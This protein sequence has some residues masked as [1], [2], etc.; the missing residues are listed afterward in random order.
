[1]DINTLL[2]ELINVIKWE[3]FTNI[4]ALTS[5]ILPIILSA[6]GLLIGLYRKYSSEKKLHVYQ[7]KEDKIKLKK[8]YVQTKGGFDNPCD[9][10]EIIESIDKN[11]IN[12]INYFI[13]D[14]INDYGF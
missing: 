14:V 8:Y 9:K 3:Y 4:I 12:L 11:R 10:E 7:T 1:M 6:L 2:E 5:L 13:H